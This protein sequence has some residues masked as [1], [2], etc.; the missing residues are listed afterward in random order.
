VFAATEFIPFPPTRLFDSPFV[1]SAPPGVFEGIV[2]RAAA[3]N[4]ELLTDP[5]CLQ[6]L[7]A[8]ENGCV[9]TDHDLSLID[10]ETIWNRLM[11]GE[12]ESGRIL[13]SRPRIRVRETEKQA[14]VL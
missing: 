4:A 12:L 11:M 9:L 2:R 7:F 8:E 10:L 6:H 5:D 3:V 13:T 14:T 1:A